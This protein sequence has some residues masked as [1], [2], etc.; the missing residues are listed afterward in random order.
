[1]DYL[2]Q[3]STRTEGDTI[4]TYYA[5]KEK[6]MPG[7]PIIFRVL[8]VR[9][10]DARA[11]ALD[12][13]TLCGLHATPFLKKYSSVE[14]NGEGEDLY[15]KIICPDVIYDELIKLTG[16]DFNGKKLVIEGETDEI[17]DEVHQNLPTTVQS[18]GTSSRTEDDVGNDKILYMLLD[19]RNNPELNFEPVKEFEVCDALHLNHADDPHKAVKTYFGNRQG[20]FGIQS[21][22]MSRY[23][24][25]TLVIRGHEIQL[26]PIRKRPRGQRQHGQQEHQKQKTRRHD[27]DGLK[28]RIFDAWDL[29]YRGIE[30]NLFD[31]H[32]QNLG[33]EVIR[34]T[35]PERC[36][37]DP[38][39]FNTNRYIV[40]KK[41]THDGSKI[42]FGNRITVDGISFKLSYYGIQRYCGLCQRSHGWDCPIKTRN[43]FLRKLREGKTD[44]AKIYSDSTLR[45]A[46]QLALTTDVAC[47]SGGGIAQMCN[48]IPY[49]KPHQEV[50]INGGTNELKE[51]SLK[52]FVYTV[53]KT[54]GKLAALAVST[55]V[56]VVLPAIVTNIPEINVKGKYLADSMKKVVN[57]IQLDAVDMEDDSHPSKD[58]TMEV[59]KKIDASKPIVLSDREEDTVLAAKYRGVQSIFKVGC[60]GCEDLNFTRSLCDKCQEDAQVVDVTALEEDIRLLKE[61]MFPVAVTVDVEMKQINNKRGPTDDNNDDNVNAAKTAR[62]S[63]D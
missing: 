17:D 8:K 60:R 24:G 31:Q 54:A 10:L 14:I 37:D 25:T 32:F 62:S 11:T 51:E 47:M 18:N 12:L 46:N 29:R 26:I 53:N 36:R 23:V 16:V 61:Q 5:S 34:S 6:G 63:S 38:D 2:N 22:D 59:V 57:V 3:N 40:V 13:A 45:H 21:T 4:V 42:D 1:M 20:T 28:I 7:V 35:Q 9:N 50:I 48:A 56:T 30:Y 41:T 43:D 27:P 52:E 33:A 15:A 58:G 39:V 19:C 49:D 44:Q 55:P